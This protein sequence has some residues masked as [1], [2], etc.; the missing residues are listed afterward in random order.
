MVRDI[1]K[2]PFLPTANDYRRLAAECLELAA[3]ALPDFRGV[4][5]SLAQGWTNLANLADRSVGDAADD[6][7]PDTLA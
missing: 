3:R 5:V 6:V 4:Y 7:P 1:V 2:G